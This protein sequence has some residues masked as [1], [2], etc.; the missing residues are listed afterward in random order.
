MTSLKDL[1]LANTPIISVPEKLA[2]YNKNGDLKSVSTLTKGGSISTR[3]GEKVIKFIG[4]NNGIFKIENEGHSENNKPE[5]K[6]ILKIKKD[7]AYKKEQEMMGG[8]DVD[9]KGP[10][11]KEM[12]ENEMMGAEDVNVKSTELKQILDFLNLKNINIPPIISNR[13]RELNL[14]HHSDLR[15]MLSNVKGIDKIKKDVLVEMI[16]KKEGIKKGI[17]PQRSNELY[18]KL[19]KLYK[20]IDEKPLTRLN[21]K[22]KEIKEAEDFFKKNKDIY[23]GYKLNEEQKRLRRINF[24]KLDHQGADT[25]RWV[26]QVKI[27]KLLKVDYSPLLE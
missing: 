7:N 9:I 20:L 17:K 22:I 1:I 16:L 4:N 2:F 21:K 3:N 18:Q 5:K 26:I 8:E 6:V 10:T 27:G 14:M 24:D 23:D 19:I 13:E 12:K 11:M 25:A 15:K